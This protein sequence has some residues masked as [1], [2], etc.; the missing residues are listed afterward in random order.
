MTEGNLRNARPAPAAAGFFAPSSARRYE[1]LA[2]GVDPTLGI[3]KTL[4]S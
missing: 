3:V 4:L 2:G 1:T